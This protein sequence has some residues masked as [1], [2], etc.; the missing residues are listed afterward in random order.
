MLNKLYIHLIGLVVLVSL[1]VACGTEETTSDPEPPDSPPNE[2]AHLEPTTSAEE[3]ELESEQSQEITQEIPIFVFGTTD[4]V[5]GASARLTKTDFELDLVINTAGLPP[6]HA[7]TVWLVIYN[8]PEE[9]S[10]GVC[11]EDDDSL[12]SFSFADGQVIDE[13]GKAEFVSNKS[14]F[15]KDGAEIQFM[16]RD[17]GPV[18]PDMVDD[19]TSK[20]GG[21]CS[22]F[23]PNT[24]PNEC[25]DV[26]M[27]IFVVQS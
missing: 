18:I 2:D 9:C 10:D 24:G 22:N 7:A 21:G 17:H 3:A 12:A 25:E 4:E 15:L 14:T 11:D 8:N 5:E 6:G 19:Q 20:P 1:L 27:G 16:I 13:S 23:E 26:Q